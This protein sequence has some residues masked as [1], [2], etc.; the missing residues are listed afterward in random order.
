MRSVY[1]AVRYVFLGFASLVLSVCVQPVD[2]DVFLRVQ[3]VQDFIEILNGRRVI[4]HPDSTPGL[5]AGNGRIL[6]LRADVYYMVEERNEN[7]DLVGFGYV[8]AD[9]RVKEE[10][11]NIGR[12]SGGE[13]IELTNRFTYTV[14]DAKPLS[15]NVIVHDLASLPPINPPSPITINSGVITLNAPKE[16]YFLDLDSINITD[17]DAADF[18]IARVR[19]SPAPAATF[20][21]NP[22]DGDFI[23][24]ETEGTGMDYVFSDYDGDGDNA[25]FVFLRVNIGERTTASINI[26]FTIADLGNPSSLTLDPTTVTIDQAE[27]YDAGV[28]I[29]ITG[30]TGFTS[31]KWMY[32]GEVVITGA[33][34]SFSRITNINYLV[35]G[36]HYFTIYI[37]VGGVEY[38]QIFTVTVTEAVFPTP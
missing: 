32:G 10:L 11:N 4:L 2:V 13:I 38:S 36:N 22:V 18:E 25:T 35:A 19:F 29:T 26:T 24:L 12:V 7:G 20:A 23:R 1:K 30:P 34:L 28:S 31:A 15:G 21:V 5:I 37:T 6:G 27:L 8:D 3:E 14:W 16:T 33:T 17:F 9:G